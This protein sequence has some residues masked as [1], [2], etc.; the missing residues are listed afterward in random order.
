[1]RIQFYHGA[2]LPSNV[3]TEVNTDSAGI[4]VYT[5][6]FNKRIRIDDY[7]GELSSVLKL[8]NRQIVEWVEKLIVKSRVEDVPWF[9]SQGFTCEAFIKNYYAGADMYFVTRYFTAGR[10]RSDKWYEEQLIL[11]RIISEPVV[12]E[13]PSILDIKIATPAQARE[14]SQLY[15]TVFKVYPTPVQEETYIL[16]TIQEGTMYVYAE[17]EGTL[18]SAASAE[19]NRKY[20]NAELTDCASHPSAEGKGYMKRLLFFLEQKLMQE[21]VTCLYTI[22]RSQSYSMNKAFAQLGYTYGGRLVNNCFIYSG[23]ENMNVWYKSV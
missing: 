1:M 10:D 8:L 16:K 13:I 9:L 2:N 4:T 19:V 7:H 22:A 17:F 21:G 6:P 23:I 3:T 11:Q 15:H 20:R 18:V 12:L 14:L 5:D